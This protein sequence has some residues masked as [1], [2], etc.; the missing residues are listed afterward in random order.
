MSSL[1]DYIS[2]RGDLDFIQSP[3]NPVDYI[4]F[5]QIS[6]LPFDGIV[7][8]P[9]EKEGISLHLA[10]KILKE[11][12]E[13]TG[14][15]VKTVLGFSEDPAFI[16]AITTSNRFRNCQLFGF[17]NQVDSEKEF[18][19]SA[20]CIYVNDGSFSIVYRGTDASFVGW[21]EDFNMAFL[22][23]IPSQIEA[24]KYLE[25]MASFVKGNLRIGGHSKGGNLAVYA[26]SFCS[27]KTQKRI[28]DIYSYDA[29]GFYKKVVISDGFHAVKNR[30]HSYIPEASVVGIILEQGVDYK[31]IKS[32]QTGLMQHSLYSWEVTHNDMIYASDITQGSRF[33]KKTIRE[34]VDSL[35]NE[36]REQFIRAI[37]TI[38]NMSEIKSIHEIEGAWLMSAG[39][40]IKS[41]GYI[42]EPTKKIIQK[43]IIELFRSASRNIDT[44]LKKKNH[45]H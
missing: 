2:W 28:T 7:P 27:G 45:E 39:K 16:E 25:K 11:K 26:A 35:D 4:I 24:V 38:L 9:E 29:P 22:E 32:S 43:T 41:M 33:L 13:S 21:K 8:S 40:I 15:I 5:S 6:Y 3:L 12:V 37:Y 30:I 10:M 44:L 23:T 18:Q 20:L 19:F 1:F 31:V 36:H 34:W 17:V 42:D 14:S